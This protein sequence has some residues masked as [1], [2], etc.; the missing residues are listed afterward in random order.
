MLWRHL[1][2]ESSQRA[3]IANV[4]GVGGQAENLSHLG[5]RERVPVDQPKDLLIR[6][7]KST[8]CGNYLCAVDNSLTTSSET[9]LFHFRRERRWLATS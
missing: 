7:G 6:V 2:A 5:A 9:T 1:V 3:V 4:G 8:K